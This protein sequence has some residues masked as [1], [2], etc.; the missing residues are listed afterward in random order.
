MNIRIIVLY[1]DYDKHLFHLNSSSQLFWSQDPFTL[2]KIIEDF[3][4]PLFMWVI[5][6]DIDQIRKL[7]L[8]NY[9]NT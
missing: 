2:L 4:E 9:K 6:I 1:T 5:A 7:K 3:K 8:R